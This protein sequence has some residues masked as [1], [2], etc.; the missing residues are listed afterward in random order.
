M[1]DEVCGIDEAIQK[2][3][4]KDTEGGFIDIRKEIFADAPQGIGHRPDTERLTEMWKD[5]LG[6]HIQHRRLVQEH[7][8]LTREVVERYV[9]ENQVR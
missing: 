4:N 5:I 2:M 9:L 7:F 3:S 1:Y 6:R 8:D